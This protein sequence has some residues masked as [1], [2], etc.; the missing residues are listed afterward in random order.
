[1]IPP[2]N[3]RDW[4][5][6][7]SRLFNKISQGSKGK[8]FGMALASLAIAIGLHFAL[9]GLIPIAPPSD[10]PKT[11]TVIAPSTSPQPVTPKPVAPPSATLAQG[12]RLSSSPLSQA[13]LADLQSESGTLI[14]RSLSDAERFQ[15]QQLLRD[16]SSAP[17]MSLG[18][19]IPLVIVHDTS[20]E[21][22]RDNLLDR[23]KQYRGPYGNGVAVYLLRSGEPIITRTDFFTRYR[24]TATAYE[25][26]LDLLPEKIRNQEARLVWRAIN[27]ATQAAALRN[28]TTTLRTQYPINASALAQRASFWLNAT[29]E[30][31][32]NALAQRGVALDGGKTTALWAIANVCEV[33]LGEANAA[34]PLAR[35]PQTLPTLQSS[36][37]RLDP[38]LR[39]NRDRVSTSVNIELIQKQGS[40]CFTTDAEVRYY[41]SVVQQDYLKIRANQVVPLQT[42]NRPAYT[43]EQYQALTLLYLKA[44]LLAGRFPAIV[45]HFALDQAQGQK[46]GDHCDPRGL[47]LLRLYSMIS[48]LLNHPPATLY[49]LKPQYGINPDQGDN[50]WWSERVLGAMPVATDDRLSSQ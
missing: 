8:S 44:A 32:Y 43:Q 28:I 42:A 6:L 12:D 9:L 24:P 40:E 45:T 11:P 14:G 49:G 36:C 33:A 2:F 47:D 41:N 29:S 46:I 17:P 22:S 16:R 35:S 23:Q 15:I 37:Q 4:T 5:S 18:N 13:L 48:Q 26:G 3:F 31:A 7:S 50:V 39:A 10:P 27:P 30:N 34:V 21:L 19:P 38:L 25:K 20:G 1:M